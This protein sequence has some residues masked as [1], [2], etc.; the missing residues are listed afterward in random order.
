MATCRHAASALP[1]PCANSAWSTSSASRFCSND[2]VD[3]PVAFWGTYPRR[4]CRDPLNTYLP[5]PQYA[6]ILDDC[7]ATA[8]V[9]DA[10]LADTIW[11]VH[12]DSCRG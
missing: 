12:R 1:M 11:P 6:Y 4:R 2:T 7:R 3:Y 9:V 10:A 5:R 8:L